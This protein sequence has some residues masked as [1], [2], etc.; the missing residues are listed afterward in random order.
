[1]VVRHLRAHAKPVV[2]Q[3]KVDA[4]LRAFTQ[5]AKKKPQ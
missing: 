3:D 1:M 5:G 4:G 2:D